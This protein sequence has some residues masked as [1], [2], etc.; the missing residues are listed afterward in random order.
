MI[1]RKRNEE[2][3]KDKIYFNLLKEKFKE[4]SNQSCIATLTIN[5]ELEIE[6]DIIKI[7]E[8]I[9]NFIHPEIRRN[10]III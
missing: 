7:S 2:N 3:S 5:D 6:R 4:L 9:Y 10:T 1:K 8:C